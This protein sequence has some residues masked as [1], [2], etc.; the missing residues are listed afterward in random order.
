[1]PR[2]QYESSGW[3]STIDVSNVIKAVI[4][5]TTLPPVPTR[6]YRAA[7][8]HYWSLAFAS[9]P[10]KTRFTVEVAGGLHEI[11]LVP[12]TNRYNPKAANNPSGKQVRKNRLTKPS[13]QP[14]P[15]PVQIVTKPSMEEQSRL[16]KLEAKV[17][18][19]ENR[20]DK[21]E[22][23]FDQ[24]LDGVD[25]ALRQTSQAKGPY[26]GH[27]PTEAPQ[28]SMR[29]AGCAP[30]VDF[31]SSLSL[32]FLRLDFRS[33]VECRGAPPCSLQGSSLW[34]AGFL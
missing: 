8:V 13:D 23:K 19:L 34:V 7:G 11:L 32:P 21:F 4:S 29:C 15:E 5:A 33:L 1:M 25:A 6:A 9:P 28:K 3:P 24:R 26:G 16:D 14:P 10:T 18:E 31:W 30:L 27:S 22:R 2:V 12:S 20:Q 17:G